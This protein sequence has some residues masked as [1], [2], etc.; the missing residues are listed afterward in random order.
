LVRGPV[1]S[2]LFSLVAMQNAA[3]DPMPS[4]EVPPGPTSK[5]PST[6]AQETPGAQETPAAPET[7][8]ASAADAAG[9]A[10]AAR[11]AK[12]PKPP[13]PPIILIPSGDSW[14]IASEDTAAVEL[15]SK[16]IEAAE[17]EASIDAI[18]VGRNGA[19]FVLKHANADELQTVLTTL[20]RRTDSNRGAGSREGDTRIVA[21]SRINALI[22]RGPSTDRDAIKELLE[23]LDSPT[24]IGIFKSPPPIF[25]PVENA[26]AKRIEEILRSVYAAQVSRGG[27]RPP[28]TIPT[29][30]SDE[31]ASMLEQINATV[32]GPLLQLSVDEVSNAIVMR[33]PPELAKEVQDF[34]KQIDN[35]ATTSRS[36]GIRVV[37]L[38]GSNA[39]TVRDLIR[40]LRSGNRR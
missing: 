11:P 34:I 7:P 37:P 4:P 2:A 35:Q 8:A 3:A 15:L 17:K 23:V 40:S 16:W 27:G 30:V 13:K 18:E 12:P 19:I 33:A 10:A 28:I 29:G 14:T 36:Q 5:G 32:S 31:I 20:Y 9:E 22:V 21:D 39:D 38:N 6:P 1:K 24:F 26:D 25:V